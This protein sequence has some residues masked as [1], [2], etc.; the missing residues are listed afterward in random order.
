[1]NSIKSKLRKEL[2]KKY[3]LHLRGGAMHV[4]KQEEDK[5]SNEPRLFEVVN[6]EYSVDL[7]K[8]TLF[9]IYKLSLS[10]DSGYYG[11]FKDTKFINYVTIFQILMKWLINI[12]PLLI[13]IILIKLRYWQHH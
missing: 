9:I 10:N 6:Q 13:K 7:N 5:S 3:L 1:M 12:I 2:L 4:N 8:N 11:L